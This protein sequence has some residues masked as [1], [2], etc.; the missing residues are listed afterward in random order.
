MRTK[1]KKVIRE[2]VVYTQGFLGAGVLQY[3]KVTSDTSLRV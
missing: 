2:R 3:I 1:N